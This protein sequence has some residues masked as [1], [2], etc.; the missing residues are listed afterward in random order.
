MKKIRPPLST[1][2]VLLDI[3]KRGYITDKEIYRLR[4][5]VRNGEQIEMIIDLTDEQFRK[6][7]KIIEKFYN[8]GIRNGDGDV[9]MDNFLFATKSKLIGFFDIG[10]D[11]EADI[12]AVYELDTGFQYFL[13]NK[14]FGI[15]YDF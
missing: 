7:L 4:N 12:E 3:A 2:R 15:Y 1:E 9:Y 13:M 11:L 10:F 6:H 8:F 5:R 14:K